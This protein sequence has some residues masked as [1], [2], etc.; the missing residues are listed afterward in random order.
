MAPDRRWLTT[1]VE[2]LEERLDELRR[3]DVARHL[4][5]SRKE[6]LLAVRAVLDQE[7]E[8]MERLAE[9]TEPR[10]IDVE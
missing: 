2:R 5:N 7:I 10:K 1:C 9:P 3:S 8:R 6:L 4:M